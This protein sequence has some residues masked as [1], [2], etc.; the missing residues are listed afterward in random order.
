MKKYEPAMLDLHGAE[1]ISATEYRMY[2]GAVR[3][4]QYEKSFAAQVQ[5]SDVIGL[6]LD[7]VEIICHHWSFH[8][9][10]KYLA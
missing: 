9:K 3:Y 7:L 4:E 8:P 6:D 2:P 1:W 5:E 10:S